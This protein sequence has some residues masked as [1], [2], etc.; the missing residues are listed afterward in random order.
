MTK[1]VA[2]CV[3]K[4]VHSTLFLGV[5]IDDKLFW[6][7]HIELLHIKLSKSVGMLK[8]ASL[9]MPRDVLLLTFYAF[10]NSHCNYIMVYWSGEILN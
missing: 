8:V 4:K 6:R 9:Y 5:V 10:F 1:T 3:I 2:N 7:E